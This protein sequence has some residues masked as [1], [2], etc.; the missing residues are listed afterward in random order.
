MGTAEHWNT[1]KSLWASRATVCPHSRPCVLPS[2]SADPAWQSHSGALAELLQDSALAGGQATPSGSLHQPAWGFKERKLSH[3]NRHWDVSQ[4]PPRDTPPLRGLHP[5][6]RLW[7]QKQTPASLL[8]PQ[9]PLQPLHPHIPATQG[10]LE[11]AFSIGGCKSVTPTHSPT[12]T[13]PRSSQCLCGSK[14]WFGHS[15]PCRN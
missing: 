3:P 5:L 11:D 13:A 7:H 2:E 12:A 8:P 4:T 6:L 1:G 10:K 14:P 9:A 15:T